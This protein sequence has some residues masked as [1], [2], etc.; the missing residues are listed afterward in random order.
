MYKHGEMC[1]SRYLD[2]SITRCPLGLVTLDTPF[3]EGFASLTG[4]DTIV[5]ARGVVTAH[6]AETHVCF[7]L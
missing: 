1:M 7:A 4:P 2:K 3:K 6:S 5:V